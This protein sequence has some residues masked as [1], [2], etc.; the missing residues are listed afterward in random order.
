MFVFIVI[1]V[2]FGGG[3]FG[4]VFVWVLLDVGFVVYGFFGC[5][6]RI[7]E[8]DVVLFCVLDVEILEVV[9]VVCLYM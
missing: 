8:V 2:V 7:F 4:V 3:W 9:F 1:F 6:V 5:G